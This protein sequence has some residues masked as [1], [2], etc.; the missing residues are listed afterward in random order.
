[1]SRTSGRTSANLVQEQITRL[2]RERATAAQDPQSLSTAPNPNPN[3]RASP[4]VAKDEL[5]RRYT[6]IQQEAEGARK[7][8]ATSPPRV[9]SA[10]DL[11]PKPRNGFKLY[12]AVLSSDSPRAGTSD[13]GMDAFSSLLED[14]L[15]MNDI[16]PSPAVDIIP[17]S[18]S[19]DYVWDPMLA[20][21]KF[22]RAS[23]RLRLTSYRT[24]LPPSITDPYDSDSDEEEEDDADE[25]S[26][27]EEYYKND[28]P[29]EEDS[30]SDDGN[31]DDREFYEDSEEEVEYDDGSD[32]DWR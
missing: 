3:P 31:V 11:P 6:V 30:V 17:P 21:C 28:Y 24:G 23:H 1:M 22:S 10:K 16:T 8:R 20:H 5:F 2:A 32:H 19:E 13:E 18:S 4:T 9:I 7:R 29:D 15:K 27:A 14:Y 26:N 12:D 25:D